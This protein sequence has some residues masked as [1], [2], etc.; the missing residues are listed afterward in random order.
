MAI[1]HQSPTFKWFVINFITKGN[2]WGIFSRN[3]HIN[4]KTGIE[5]NTYTTIEKAEKAVK[6]MDKKG[7]KVSSYKCVFCDGYHL[8]KDRN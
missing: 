4:Q 6:G 7:I 8:G 1:R 2:G 5:K 3:S